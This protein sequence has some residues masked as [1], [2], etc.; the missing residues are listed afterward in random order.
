MNKN[1][2]NIE[3]RHKE[4]EKEREKNEKQRIKD[5]KKTQK[6]QE[7]VGLTPGK[8]DDETE[9]KAKNSRKIIKRR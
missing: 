3:Q 6:Y 1:Y 7:K 5:M 4:E 2:K 9:K 8:L